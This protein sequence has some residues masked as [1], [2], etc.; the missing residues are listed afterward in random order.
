MT[1]R[2]KGEQEAEGPSDIASLVAVECKSE[3]ESLFVERGIE[4]AERC[5]FEWEGRP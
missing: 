2:V 5:P 4:S 1:I 3:F